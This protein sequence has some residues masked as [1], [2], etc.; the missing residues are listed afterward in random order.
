MANQIIIKTTT[1]DSMPVEFSAMRI[2]TDLLPILMDRDIHIIS[3]AVP[4]RM[5]KDPE[6]RMMDMINTVRPDA[7]IVD[8]GVKYETSAWSKAKRDE[9]SYWA[10]KGFTSISSEDAK[11]LGMKVSKIEELIRD[12]CRELGIST[13]HITFGIPRRV[14]KGDTHIPLGQL[15]TGK[16]K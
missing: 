9:I 2:I 8:S 10:K 7:L 15:S 5:A 16:Y 1:G 3:I 12:L 4:S 11:Y 13:S 14:K 6:K